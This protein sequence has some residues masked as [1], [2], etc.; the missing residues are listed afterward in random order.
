MKALRLGTRGSQLA[1]WQARTTAA[2]L[3]RAGGPLCEV[4]VIKTSGDRLAEAPLSEVGG[5]R[6]FKSAPQSRAEIHRALVDGVPYAMLVNL[7]DQL[8]ALSPDDVAAAV[9]ISGRTLRRHQEQPHKTM[10][11]DLAS[12]LDFMLARP[13]LPPSGAYHF[14]D[15]RLVGLA[16]REEAPDLDEVLTR[17]PDL[18]ILRLRYQAGQFSV[19]DRTEQTMRGRE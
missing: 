14:G 17:L 1:L 13:P 5:K 8:G 6:L 9:G 4:V 19:E 11:P 3:E 7:V 15:A 16:R 12:R 18:R 10:P 2:L